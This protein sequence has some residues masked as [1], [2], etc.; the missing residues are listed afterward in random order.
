MTREE[1]IQKAAE[2]FAFSDKSETPD[3]HD[4]MND[5]YYGAKWADET[6]I[7]KAYEWLCKN[8]TDSVYLGA[9]TLQP[10]H[11]VDFIERFKEAMEL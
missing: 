5:F 2:K 1:E 9:N 7:E 8:M 4:A 3:F 10:L 6:M 11:K